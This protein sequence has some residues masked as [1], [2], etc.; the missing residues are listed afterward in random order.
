MQIICNKY[1]YQC[2]YAHFPFIYICNTFYILKDMQIIHN[3]YTY[4]SW[5]AH[6]PFIYR[7]NS[8]HNIFFIATCY[9]SCTRMIKL[10]IRV[11]LVVGCPKLPQYVFLFL[12][13]FC[14]SMHHVSTTR[15]SDQ[16][17]TKLIQ[18]SGTQS[19]NS[20][21]QLTDAIRPAPRQIVHVSFCFFHIFCF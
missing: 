12:L 6:F 9:F 10:R 5:Y 15:R 3:K 16:H 17:P 13:T 19:L 8:K 11:V 18:S 21:F 2:W 4:Q 7:C 1:T 20:S 14:V